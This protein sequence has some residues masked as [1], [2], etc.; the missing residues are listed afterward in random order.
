MFGDN[1][2]GCEDAPKG[3]RV[4]A[5]HNFFGQADYWTSIQDCAQPIPCNGNTCYY[6]MPQTR[7][8]RVRSKVTESGPDGD[9][10]LE[11]IV[12]YDRYYGDVK[13][14]LIRDSCIGTRYEYTIDDDG[15]VTEE[16][17]HDT[18]DLCRSLEFGSGPGAGLES[19]EG[20]FNLA[21]NYY[22]G[23]W[24]DHC[25]APTFTHTDEIFYEDPWTRAEAE[26]IAAALPAPLLPSTSLAP[27]PRKWFVIETGALIGLARLNGPAVPVLEVHQGAQRYVYNSIHVGYKR[28]GISHEEGQA[29]PTPRIKIELQGPV[30]QGQWCA[31]RSNGLGGCTWDPLSSNYVQRAIWY[32]PPQFG[33]CAPPA[34]C[35]ML[36]ED[37]CVNIWVAAGQYEAKDL[38]ELVETWN[39]ECEQMIQ[40]LCGRE[41]HFA[42]VHVFEFPVPAEYGYHGTAPDARFPACGSPAPTC[43][44]LC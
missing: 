25:D 29:L 4:A 21:G 18:T 3:C 5:T 27:P 12:E 11:T 41:Q 16:G 14:T 28:G 37:K 39:V 19:C 8:L 31:P 44:P 34:V 17:P 36:P 40:R 20:G 6:Q 35:C 43:A 38:V 33:Q 42:A 13:H 26:A 22:Y 1:C 2:C 32:I 10:W 7:Y 24:K 15:H 23:I 9:A 30:W